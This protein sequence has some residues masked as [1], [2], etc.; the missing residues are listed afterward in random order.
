MKSNHKLI[1]QI[2]TFEYQNSVLVL[3]CITRLELTVLQLGVQKGR[4]AGMSKY[5]KF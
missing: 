1:E 3:Y 2:K 5:Y 4:V